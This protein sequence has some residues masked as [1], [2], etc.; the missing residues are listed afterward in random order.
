MRSEQDQIVEGLLAAYR[1]GFFPMA[2]PAFGPNAPLLWVS[3]EER[4]VIPL[5]REQGFHVPRRLA[6]RMRA[7]PFEITSD[8]AFEAVIHGCAAPRWY[9]RESWI[10]GR[11]IGLYT[12]L[13]RRGY[14]HS[15]EAWLTDGGERRLVG[16]LYGLRIGGAFF[17]ESK[18]CLPEQGGSDAS[19]IVLV[20]LVEHLQRLGFGLLDVQMW[21]EHL[22][23]FGCRTIPRQEYLRR[24]AGALAVPAEWRPLSS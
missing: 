19:K 20:T 21:N 13:H 16:G 5:T 2:E 23:R 24:L 4:G 22:D 10:D 1:Q 12:L 3:P 18:F 14:A 8:T 15:L 11:I 6:S 17:A 7:R 9:E